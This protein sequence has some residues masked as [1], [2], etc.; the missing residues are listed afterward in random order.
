MATFHN[1]GATYA[2]ERAIDEHPEIG[3]AIVEARRSLRA[4]DRYDRTVVDFV[5]QN[6]YSDVSMEDAYAFA[7]V[8]SLYMGGRLFIARVPVGA[9]PEADRRVDVNDET[10]RRNLP[11]G[12]RSVV[13][14]GKY[15]CDGKLSWDF[16][17][18]LRGHIEKDDGAVVSKCFFEP[19]DAPLEIG[20]TH[21]SRSVTHLQQSRAL[22][23]WPYG[24]DF[25]LLGRL[26]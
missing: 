23:R 22:A 14:G 9:C 26:L 8:W 10:L 17:I 15:D 1:Y 19:G 3:R 2:M 12:F 21:A 4:N 13:W 5:F 20:T 25:I 16:E 7:F 6:H 11:H 24:R 18:G